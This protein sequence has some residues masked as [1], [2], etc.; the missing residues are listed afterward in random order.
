MK[1]SIASVSLLAASLAAGCS[2][3]SLNTASTDPQCLRRGAIPLASDVARSI[4]ALPAAHVVA[5]TGGGAPTFVRGY[6]GLADHGP[7]DGALVEGA[8]P[9]VARAFRIDAADL[10]PTRTMTDAD[11]KTHTFFD[12]TIHGLRVINGDFGVHVNARGVIYAAHGLPRF[13][14]APPP[15]PTIL[16]DRVRDVLGAT[17]GDRA[18][19]SQEL[20]YMLDGDREE[21]LLV[22]ETRIDGATPLDSDWVWLDA[23]TGEVVATEPVAQTALDRRIHDVAGGTGIPG[24]LV[25][26]EG[27]GPNADRI[28]QGNYNEI[29]RAYECYQAL[30]NRDSWDGLGRTIVSSVNWGTGQQAANAFFDGSQIAF[31]SGDGQLFRNLG[32]SFDVVVHE[33]GH[34]VI[35]ETAG[36]IYR[37]ESGALNEAFADI[38]QAVCQA[39]TAGAVTEETWMVGEDVFTPGT[40]GDALRYMNAPERDGISHDLYPGYQGEENNGGVHMNSG[41][42]NLTF[43]LLTEGGTHPSFKTPTLIRRG[44][45]IEAAGQIFYR[46]LSTYM[47]A[48]TNFEG[49][50]VATVMAANDL[51]GAHTGE[52]VHLAWDTVAVPGASSRTPLLPPLE[53]NI[54]PLT[55]GQAV[56]NLGA[57]AGDALI[58]SIQVPPQ[59]TNLSFEITG[60]AGATGDAD[61]YVR[62]ASVPT[63]SQYDRAPLLDGSE[64]RA[65][66]ETPQPDTYYVAVHAFDAFSGVTLEANYY[67][68]GE[69][70]PADDCD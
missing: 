31:G 63:S 24:P 36:L 5:N 48:S 3:G 50:R 18:L 62:R 44:I 41:I 47:N 56:P 39:R 68:P 45:G 10:A 60:S 61:L 57:A 54:L 64:E 65:E 67:L 35:Q 59:A 2:P 58:F 26:T 27:D 9:A 33:L 12:Q 28:V 22:Y 1:A 21:L 53:P 17:L 30:F 52:L 43:K 6:L 37:N 70:I 51:Y 23:H 16:S 19:T 13:N 7:M 32:D 42:A 29:G 20:A 38:F 55:R 14:S 25:M 11:G 4:A 15:Q 8:L 46:A 49:A 69:E 66:Y 34:G 40:Q